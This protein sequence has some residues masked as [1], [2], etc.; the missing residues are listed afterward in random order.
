MV[1]ERIRRRF[2][3]CQELAGFPREALGLNKIRLEVD[4]APGARDSV[5][6]RVTVRLFLV[7]KR[8]GYK[9]NFCCSEFCRRSAY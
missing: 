2:G 4:L 3:D 8:N 9:E 7:R 1:P 5:S 6:D